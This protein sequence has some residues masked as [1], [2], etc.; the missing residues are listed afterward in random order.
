MK[1]PFSTAYD[2]IT[3]GV[4]VTVATGE[5]SEPVSICT[6]GGAD[7]DYFTTLFQDEDGADITS[8]VYADDNA[9]VEKKGN[10]L[11]F[12]TSDETDNVELDLFLFNIT[13]IP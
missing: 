4:M 10:K 7:K 12:I 9:F 2:L 5:F 11:T 6:S 8:D 1:I 13:P 3:S